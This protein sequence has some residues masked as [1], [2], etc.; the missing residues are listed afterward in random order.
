MR[1]LKTKSF[2]CIFVLVFILPFSQAFGWNIMFDVGMEKASEPSGAYM[3]EFDK[4]SSLIGYRMSLA[5]SF[6]SGI[7]FGREAFGMLHTIRKDEGRGTASVIVGGFVI[8]YS[9]G[10]NPRLTLNIGIPLEKGQV[11]I[12]F[13]NDDSGE[14]IDKQE[15]LP[16]NWGGIMLDLGFGKSSFGLALTIN[17]VSM[18]TDDFGGSGKSFNAS[19]IYPGL[20]LRWRFGPRN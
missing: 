9:I 10:E 20:S 3:D 16:A 1:I 8:G 7:V 2:L 4:V 11:N 18:K 19:G 15:Y 6:E 14:K 17:Y 5:Y 13:E 12:S